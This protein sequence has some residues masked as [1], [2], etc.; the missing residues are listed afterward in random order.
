MYLH[1]FKLSKLLPNQNADFVFKCNWEKKWMQ[2]ESSI[3]NGKLW[4]M[5]KFESLWTEEYLGDK[6]HENI[7][8]YAIVFT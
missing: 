7:L 1:F 2:V 8:V 3:R 5:N 6:I 4:E